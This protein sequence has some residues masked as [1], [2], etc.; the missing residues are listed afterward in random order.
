MIL[1]KL[2][3]L[4]FSSAL[5]LS[6]NFSSAQDTKST[7]EQ[8]YRP[9]FHFT[10]K[11]NW[12]NDPN[13]LFYAD[14]V[15]H[16]YFQYWPYGNK[17]GPMHWGHATSKDLVKWEEQPIALYPDRFGYIFSGSAVLDVNNTSGFGNGKNAPVVAIFTYH[18]PVKEKAGAIDVESQGLAYS[19]DNGYN[20]TKYDVGNPVVKNPGIRD[21]RD[22]KVTWDSI[23]NQWIMVLAAQDRSQLY[24]SK[25]LKDWNYLSDFGKNIG[26]HGGVWECPDFFPMKVEGTGE[27]KWVLIQSLN[28]GGAN[29]GS[30]TQ[31]FVGD[32][33]GK[34]F[35]LDKAFAERVAKEKAVWLDHGKDNYAGV[36]WGN[37]PVKDG[38][39]MMIGWMSNWEYAEVVPTNGWRSSNTI[40]RELK[41]VKK[42]GKY[43]LLTSPSEAFKNYIE[44]T[45]RQ[46]KIVVKGTAVLS[47]KGTTDLTRADI[48]FSVKDLKQDVYTFTFSNDAGETLSF[49]I[50]NKAHNLFI[51]R[52]KSGSAPAF[53]KFTAT[54]SKA[55]LSGS[56]KAVTFRILMDKTSIEIFYNDGET[57]MTEI[58]F[59]GAPFNT[60]SAAA[61]SVFEINDLTINQLK[62]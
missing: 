48:T 8:M 27:T 28:P 56:Q 44:K 40:P 13:G 46:K 10:P 14:G 9:N 42:D 49:G 3:P 6:A 54:P 55:A 16:L 24:V 23:H 51:D 45:D 19:L 36:T 1:K 59:A 33:D 34:T 20:W 25:N 37:A 58:F 7:E 62:F 26:A 39:R 5:L 50:D 47:Q 60:L 43:A 32:F 31:Y 38:R 15:Y 22:P 4:A 30:G 17:W 12:M 61:S 18:D 41:L 35:T 2:L 21:F 52:Q 53:Q 57:V 29:G 11:N